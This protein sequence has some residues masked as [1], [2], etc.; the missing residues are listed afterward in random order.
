MLI[1]FYLE[2]KVIFLKQNKKKDCEHLDEKF[3]S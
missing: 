2:Q 1:E 3:N